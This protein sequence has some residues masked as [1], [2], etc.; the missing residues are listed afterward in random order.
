MNAVLFVCL[1]CCGQPPKDDPL[2]KG[3]DDDFRE[4]LKKEKNLGPLREAAER[5]SQTNQNSRWTYYKDGLATLRRHRSPAGVALVLRYTVE[6]AGSSNSGAAEYAETFVILTGKA[7]PE[8]SSP[9]EAVAQLV[10]TWWD[11]DKVVTNLDKM[12]REQVE[13]IVGHLLKRGAAAW[14]RDVYSYRQANGAS[15]VY[16]VLGSRG[17]YRRPTSSTEVE[18]LHPRMVEMILKQAG[19]DPLAKDGPPERETNRVL[20]EGVRMLAILRNEGEAPTLDAVA[21]DA[22]QNSAVR[23]TCVL[24]LLEAGEDRQAPLLLEILE[25]E[26]KLERRLTAIAALH[27]C[28]RNQQAVPKLVALLDDANVQIRAA[29]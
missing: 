27:Y 8:A 6:H 22:K 26:K 19:H 29:A 12:S 17:Y 24:A 13:T 1:L 10:K 20:F 21:R 2:L 9:R 16:G 28:D 15:E 4:L 23:L 3:L 14:A 18:E 11:K 7:W 25:K 5:L